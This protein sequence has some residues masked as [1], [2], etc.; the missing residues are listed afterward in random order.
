MVVGGDGGVAQLPGGAYVVVEMRERVAGLVERDEREVDAELHTVDLLKRR[1]GL[2]EHDITAAC[3][4]LV[5][6]E[7]HGAL[8]L[9][10][11]RSQRSQAALHFI[12]VTSWARTEYDLD[13]TG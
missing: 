6:Q 11:Y 5:P 1:D 10:K 2:I 12:P 8:P 9:P 4:L 7:A 3:A 13:S